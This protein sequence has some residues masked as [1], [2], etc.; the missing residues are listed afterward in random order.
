MLGI[1]F[2][3]GVIVHPLNPKA[4]VMVVMVWG[5]FA[6][7]VGDFNVQLPIVVFCF[8][9]CQLIFHSFW[10]ALG[11]YL[12]RSFAYNH[13]LAKSMII[14]TILVVLVTLVYAPSGG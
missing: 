9:A 2:R 6:P 1:R 10:C 8:T 4:W 13:I 12:G 14:L 11:A 7:A 5:Q 3:D